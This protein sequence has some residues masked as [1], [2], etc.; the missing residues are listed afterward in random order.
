METVK[1]DCGFWNPHE[2]TKWEQYEEHFK[3]LYHYGA[4]AGKE[5][6]S[7]EDWQKRHCVKC[8]KE[9]REEIL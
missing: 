8:G 5:I 9:Q 1:Q 6:P 3:F 7:A 2:W 4:N